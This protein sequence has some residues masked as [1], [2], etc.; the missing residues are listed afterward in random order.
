MKKIIIVFLI[1]FVSFVY[2]VSSLKVFEINETEKLSLGL[3]VED[4]D[5]DT[6]IYTFTEPL[7]RNGEWQT[8]YGD[9]GEYIV[10]V[11]VSDGETEVTEEVK[12]IVYRKEAEPTIDSF[13]PEEEVVVIDEGNNVEFKVDASDL[14]NDG[15]AYEW[16]VNDEVVSTSDEMLFETGYNDAGDYVI[17]FVLSDDVFNVSKEWNVRVNDVDL[18]NILEQIKDV[19]VLETETASLELPDFKK[20]G[21]S[22]TI[23]E[24]LGNKNKW[25]TDYDDAGE[26]T[27]NIKASGKDFEGQTDVKVTVMNNDRAPK[28]IGL[29]NA[30]VKEN[31]KVVLVIEAVD[32]DKDDIILSAENIPENAQ[33]DG[34]VFTWTP[35][36]DFVQKNNAFDRLLDKFKILGRS[37]DIAF[38]AQSNEL[39]DRK[40]VRIRVKDVNRP[41]V[42]EDIEDI[43]VDEGDVIFIEPKYNDPDNDKV[44]FSYSGFMNRA[45]KNVGFDDAGNYIVKVTA[46][47]GF[48]TETRLVNVEV[49][50][51][52]RKP[53]FNGLGNFEVDEGEELRVELSASDPDNDAV[54]FSASRL[55]KGAVLKDNLFLWEPGFVVVN[56]TKKEFNVEFF[57]SDGDEE[58]S[59]KVKITVLDVNQAPEIVDYSNDLIA[60]RGKPILFEVNA[61]DVDG[62]EL[63]YDW[64][65]G[66]FSRYEGENQHQRILSSAGKKKVEV[67]VSDGLQSVSKVWN[68]LV[69]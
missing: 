46:T 14:N 54:G 44:S 3:N 15:L 4:P 40:N 55:P 68:V 60:V 67:I 42:L 28:L 50:D 48:F 10:I 35:S 13:V 37:V 53:V 8:T 45:E 62:D 26:H 21:L 19:T 65:F 38:T 36:Y 69:V 22:Y 51:V 59:Q 61:V 25:K 31:E 41:F 33:L 5:E 11:G 24:P 49:D 9:A 34:D 39:S 12:I 7:D 1:L 66:L 58:V 32:P 6:L 23:S 27:V 29:K 47:D 64:N 63:T 52:N 57:A 2:T 18:N 56:G 17:S 20:Y 43:D 30:R 16:S